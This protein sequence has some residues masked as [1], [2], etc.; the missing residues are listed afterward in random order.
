MRLHLCEA[1][2]TVKHTE[3]KGEERLAGAGGGAGLQPG[4]VNTSG[5]RW[6]DSSGNALNPIGLDTYKWLQ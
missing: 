1:P 3:R 4:T 2:R 5:P 6:L